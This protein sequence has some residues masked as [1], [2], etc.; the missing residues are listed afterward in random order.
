MEDDAESEALST[1]N[2]TYAV[3]H[4]GPEIP[5][6]PL[7]WMRV[8]GKNDRL[9]LI[10]FDDMRNRLHSRSLLDQHEFASQVVFSGLAQPKDDLEW[11][12]QITV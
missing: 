7:L 3:P 2:F 5:P 9:A 8:N 12:K 11:K 10:Q 1:G 4:R 6:L